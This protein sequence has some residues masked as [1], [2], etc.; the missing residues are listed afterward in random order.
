[1]TKEA[2]NYALKQL[3]LPQGRWLWVYGQ[4]LRAGDDYYS[5]FYGDVQAADARTFSDIASLPGGY[6]AVLVACPKQVEET[7]GLIALA[8]AQSSGGVL[9]IAAND[10][11]G[12][13]LAALFKAY[14]VEVQEYT[15]HKCR[16][17]WI[18]NA[19]QADAALVRHNLGRLQLQQHEIDGVSWW[20]VPGLFGWNKVDK[21]SALLLRYLPI[22]LTGEVADFG[23][24]YGYISKK[25]ASFDRVSRVDAYDHDARAIAA[26]QKN[27]PLKMRAI[28]QDITTYEPRRLYEAVVMNPPFHEGK[29][30]DIDL[31]KT[32]LHKAWA[33]LK[34][35]GQLWLVA[36]SKLPYEGVIPALKIV[37]EEAGYKILM[38]V[39]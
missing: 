25:L 35:D 28:W 9:A 33:S 31:G 37:H 8:L 16:I 20:T 4:P 11:G 3:S 10:A 38:G 23:C 32:F 39:A 14:G 22:N 24:G 34:P 30:E 15:K 1:M 12:K 19:K 29:R 26:V 21:G 5:P 27:V 17:V 2:F 7:E 6:N 18:A 36:N 13:R